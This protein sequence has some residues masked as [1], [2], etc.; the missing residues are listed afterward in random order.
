MAIN[1]NTVYKTVLLILN[2]EER[3]Y[4]TPDEFNKIAT[5]VQLE[6][7]EQYGEDLNQQLRVPQTDT[8]YADRVAAIDE[9]L[10]IF[11]TSGPASFV[12]GNKVY[13][14]NITNGGAGY[15]T[16]ILATTSTSGV[17]LTIN[18]TVT[19][20][21]ITSATINNPGSNYSTGDIIKVTGGTGAELTIT[22]VTSSQHFTLPTTDVFNNTVELY[23]LGVVNYKEEVELQRLQRMDF[24]NIQKSPLTKSTL[25]FPTYLLENERLFVKPDT[26]ISNV[27]CDFLRKP[28]DPR[29]GYSIGTVGQYVYDST[30]YGPLLL[31]TGSVLPNTGIATGNPNSYTNITSTSSG[32]GIGLIMSANVTSDTTVILTIT[33]AG[34][35]YLSGD[36]V[37]VTAGQLG[38]GSSATTITLTEANFNANSTY[39]STQIEL[40]VSEQ[41]SFILKTLFYFGVV[42]KDPQIIQVAASKIQQEENNSKR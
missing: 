13:S 40:D 12:A 28:L 41:T 1:V 17:G 18:A 7:F 11:K 20:T 22:S 25:S 35:G 29:W 42:V 21:V 5:Q 14:F 27:N 24:Y 33:S 38:T 6:I 16:G 32:S 39:G 4:V 36:T 3:G 30:V 10:S 19:A 9:H 8:D 31:N 26:I 23:R 37:T 2:K 15:T 34:T